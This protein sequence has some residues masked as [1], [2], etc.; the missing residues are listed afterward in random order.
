VWIVFISAIS[1][2]IGLATYGYNVTRA[3]GTKMSKLSASR[4]FA[5]ELATATVILIASQYG[6]AARNHVGG[7][8]LCQ[9]ICNSSCSPMTACDFLPVVKI[10][11]VPAHLQ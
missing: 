4:G 1:M 2:V 9:C 10:V 11:F 6:S 5:A 7:L 3:V 8:P